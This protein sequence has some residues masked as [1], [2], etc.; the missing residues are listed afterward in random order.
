MVRIRRPR[1]EN[2]KNVR[3]KQVLSVWIFAFHDGKNQIIS[4]RG[5][6]PPRLFRFI[7]ICS[8]I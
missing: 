8:T 2:Q 7:S 6:H 5:G 4:G 1:S 3:R